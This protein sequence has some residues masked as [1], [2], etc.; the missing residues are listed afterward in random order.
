MSENKISSNEVPEKFAEWLLSMGCPAEKIPQMDKVVQMCRGQY[1]MV[2]RSIMERVEARGSIRQKR[3]QVFSDDVRRYQ[4]ANS[5]DTSIIVPAEIQAWRKHK[6]VKE[7]VAKA[8]ARVKDANKK[9]NQVMDKVS[10]KY[11]MSVPFEE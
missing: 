7:K 8:E 3:L 5:H 4:R 11:F 10:T 9:L 1:Y 2:W 6:E